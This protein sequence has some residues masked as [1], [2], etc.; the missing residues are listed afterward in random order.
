MK[1]RFVRFGEI[2]I[3][4]IRYNQDVVLTNGQITP[5]DKTPSRK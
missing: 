3:D 4:G 1:A 5:R 2:E